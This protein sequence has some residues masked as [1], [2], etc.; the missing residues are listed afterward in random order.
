MNRNGITA[1]GNWIVD[2]VKQVD[3]LPRRGMLA[4]IKSMCFS[5]GGAPANVLNDLARLQAPFPL[6]GLGV[7]GDDADGRYLKQTFTDLGVDV[8]AL[9]TTTEAPTSF[10]DV[11]NDEANG[12]RVFF[13][14][15]GANAL[16][17]PGHVDIGQLKCRIFHLGYLLLLD[18]MDRPDPDCGTVAAK[19]LRDVQAA[20]ILTSVDVVS[21]EGDRFSKY[22]PP[23]LKYTDYLILNE[24]EAGRAVGLNVRDASGLLEGDALVEAVERLYSF[25]NMKLVA[26]H[27]P[28]GVYL[29]EQNGQRHSIGSLNLPKGYIAGA[30]GAGDA[31]CAGMLYGLHEGGDAVA[32]ARL[33]NCCAAAS[34]SR[35][36]ASEGIMPL[37]ETLAL[38]SRFGE[39]K[40]PLP[41]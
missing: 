20:G 37:A 2:R 33:G 6:V 16:F 22:V 1:A 17:Q 29:R 5:P 26:V 12:N 3:C 9:F 25:G 24:I 18:A 36:G 27:M 13:H 31:F 19:L 4:N 40:P 21:E 39:R 32:A 34:L 14:H 8:S 15:R 38:A 28:E 41:I 30:V 10:T 35:P 23:A 7:V 11:M